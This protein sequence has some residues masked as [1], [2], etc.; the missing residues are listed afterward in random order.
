MNKTMLAALLV[1]LSLITVARAEEGQDCTQAAKD[2]WLGEDVIKERAKAAGIDVR[3]VKV[4]GT[5]YEVYGIDA[6][7]S[8]VETLFNPETGDAVANESE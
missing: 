5:C 7:G 8:K 6:K 3:Q 4:E 1:T 2:K